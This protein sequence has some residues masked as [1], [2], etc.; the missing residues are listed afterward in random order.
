MP[1]EPISTEALLRA[2]LES[3][4][5]IVLFALDRD[6]RYLAF[7]ENHRAIMAEIWGAE[8]EIGHPMLDYIHR[9]DDRA[10]AQRNF[11]RAL[12]GEH[13]VLNES[14]GEL[15]RRTYE[16]A[17]GPILSEQGQVIGL[18]VFLTDIT[19]RL[20]IEEEHQE[21]QEHLEHLVQMR[22]RDLEAAHIQLVRSQKSESLGIM[23]AGLAHD[24]N[25]L[26]VGILGCTDLALV[27]LPP[28][29]PIRPLVE[30][31]ERSASRAAGLTRQ[32]LTYAGQIPSKIRTLDLNAEIR[33]NAALLRASLPPDAILELDLPEHLP[34]LQGD[35]VQLLAA[36]RNLVVNAG[37]ALGEGGHT[38]R[39]QTGT[40]D[41]G[42]GGL[43]DLCS[44]D[45]LAIGTHVIV[46]VSD[47]GCGLDQPTQIRMFDP[48][49]TT[50]FAGRGLGLASVQG[51]VR[52]HRGGMRVFSTLGEGSI[53]EILLPIAPEGPSRA[54]DT[55]P[56]PDV[57][58][59][60]VLVIDD[61]PQVRMV[62]AEMLMRMGFATLEA[63]DGQQGLELLEARQD[64][65]VAVI[66]DM[67]MPRMDGELAF[68]RLR[69][70]APGLP[71]VVISGW[72]REHQRLE[73]LTGEQ[74]AAFLQKPFRV[75]ELRAAMHEIGA[76]R[77]R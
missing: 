14:Y 71:I 11:D 55:A 59:G 77:E 57:T 72:M 63:G 21:H 16:D 37:E 40:L 66:L 5:R 15:E 30:Q 4:R 22:T 34:Q 67:T 69:A 53:F 36:I 2:I 47:D 17:Y 75:A 6:Y 23:A 12:A 46:R 38:V 20:K 56:A 13:F 76:L 73:F 7:N 74:H 3:P 65:V 9:D 52:S 1:V 60:S 42:L 28:N 29:A 54:P 61:E 32:L 19:P 48:F 18:T 45:V 24:F 33:H 51:I 68:T 43:P 44:D 62:A 25:N 27:D 58:H 64:T 39:I 70:L 26:L 10:R 35:V 8:I 50:K 31:I 41:V 49:F